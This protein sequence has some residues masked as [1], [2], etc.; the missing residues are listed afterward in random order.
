[1]GRVKK[2]SK[3]NQHKSSKLR[4]K[5][6]VVKEAN[7][8]EDHSEDNEEMKTDNKAGLSIAKR[9]QIFKKKDRRDV[10]KRI[11]ELRMQSLKLKKRNLD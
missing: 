6:G 7:I 4:A 9:K 5:A 3:H 1:M 8:D 2:Y 11:K 10:K